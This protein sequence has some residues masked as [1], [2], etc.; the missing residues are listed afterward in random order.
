MPITRCWSRSPSPTHAE[1]APAAGALRRGDPR[2][3]GR[4]DRRDR[5]AAA[6]A[7]AAGWAT[8]L[9]LI[10]GERRWRAARRAGLATMPAV[11]RTTDDVRAVEQALV[12]NLHRQDLTPLEEAAAYQQLIEDFDL[13]HD[14]VVAARRQEPLGGHQHAATARPA[15]GDP[16]PARRRPAVRRARPSAARHA[17]SSPAGAP[18]P[19][20][21]ERG[22][23]GA[24]GRG[25]GA[26]RGPS[27]RPPDRRSPRSRTP[28]RRRRRPR[29]TRRACAR[30]ACSSSSNCWPMRSTPGWACRWGRSG[31]GS[32][33]TSPT[34]RTSSGSIA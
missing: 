14:D 31:A 9:Q 2:R 19:P 7:G 4:V 18:G 23:V 16:A 11:I 12:E 25:V 22:L 29:S 24:H 10:A 28:S 26:Q 8:S 6:G 34:S 1:P 15:A 21:G 5:R 30:P 3:A 33:S 27:R 13:T 32:R 17:G 20:G